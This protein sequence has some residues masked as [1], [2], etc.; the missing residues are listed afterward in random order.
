MERINYRGFD[1]SEIWIHSSSWDEGEIEVSFG[2]G[3]MIYSWN[4]IPYVPE[5][6]DRLFSRDV[7]LSEKWAILKD[8]ISRIIDKNYESYVPKAEQEGGCT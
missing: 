7:P 8:D 6:H 3:D 2:T 1:I 4:F 5:L